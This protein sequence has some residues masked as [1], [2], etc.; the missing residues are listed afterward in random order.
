MVVFSDAELQ[1]IQ[2]IIHQ[3]PVESEFSFRGLS[4]RL[5]PIA[6]ERQSTAVWARRLSG[7]IAKS[8][9]DEDDHRLSIR[10]LGFHPGG[11]KM[12]RDGG[13]IAYVAIARD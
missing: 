2:E 1:L 9:D 5:E 4:R 7:R 10:R 12:T 8:V 13:S 11:A 6:Q 3:R